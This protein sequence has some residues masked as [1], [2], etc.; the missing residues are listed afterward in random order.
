MKIPLKPSLLKIRRGVPKWVIL[1]HTAEMYDHPGA[2]I[3][4]PKH[5]LPALSKGVLEKKQGDINYNYVI[6]RIGEEFIP[7]VCRPVVYMCDWKDI[8]PDV[9]N[10]AVHIAL[11]GSYDFTIP[12]KRL[13]EVLAFRLL[14]PMLKL[15]GLTPSKIKFHRNVSTNKDLSCPGDFVDPAVVEAMV[16]RFVIK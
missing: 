15:W 4:N 14:N 6:E 13:Y 10:R 3:D 7:I 16:R 1:H 11:L 5:Q 9:N 8:R 12:E 2:K